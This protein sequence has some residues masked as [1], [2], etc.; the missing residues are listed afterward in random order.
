LPVPVLDNTCIRI[1]MDINEDSLDLYT[2][3]ISEDYSNQPSKTDST[4]SQQQIS[5]VLDTA[6][7]TIES[8]N[9]ELQEKAKKEA[10]LQKR[11]EILEKNNSSLLLTAKSELGRKNSIISDLRDQIDEHTK[12]LFY[13]GKFNKYPDKNQSYSS[14]KSENSMNVSPAIN[15]R[16]R[17]NEVTDDKKDSKRCRTTRRSEDIVTKN[18]SEIE[19]KTVKLMG[20]HS[21]KTKLCD[22][23]STM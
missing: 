5:E 3:L 14:R 9:I 7:A 22:V 18:D 6:K 21:P 4:E 2:D 23:T 1:I 13:N 10:E 12:S 20:S 16:K 11:I 15:S 19:S 17:K 8:L